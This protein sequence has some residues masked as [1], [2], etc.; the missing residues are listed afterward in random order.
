[1]DSHLDLDTSLGEALHDLRQGVLALG[2]GHSVSRHDDD[3]FRCLQPCGH[4]VHLHGRAL[5]CDVG[6]EIANRKLLPLEAQDVQKCPV[7]RRAHDGRQN[8]PAGADQSADD[9]QQRI[10]Q[11]EAL[12]SKCPAGGAVKQ[13][14]DDR[15]VGTADLARHDPTKNRGDASSTE[16]HRVP[17]STD[18]ADQA[19]IESNEEECQEGLLAWEVHGPA[20]HQALQLGEGQQAACDRKGA[21]GGGEVCRHGEQRPRAMRGEG[22]GDGCARSG[23]THKAVEGRNKLGQICD[24]DARS[25]TNTQATAKDHCAQHLHQSGLRHTHGANRASKSTS[26]THDAKRIPNGRGLLR[27]QCADGLDAQQRRDEV[28]HRRQAHAARDTKREE[29][30]SWQREEGAVGGRVARA[31]EHLQHAASHDEAS[32]NIHH[33]NED[34]DGSKHLRHRLRIV[35]TPGQHQASHN[36]EAADRIGHRHQRRVQSSCNAGDHLRPDQTCKAEGCGQRSDGASHAA[37]AEETRDASGVHQR[38]A[39]RGAEGHLLGVHDLCLLH[40][41]LLLWRGRRWR[42]VLRLRQ[43]LA[44]LDDPAATDGLIFLVQVEARLVAHGDQ[45]LGDIVREQLRGLG[46]RGLN[47]VCP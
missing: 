6:R 36:G 41:G 7:H 45:E 10:R 27:R 4:V 24:L 46:G 44:I 35:A 47:H 38:L 13:R 39:E 21:D 31:A 5:A 20:G 9:R 15:H 34:G 17:R 33:G 14:D 42:L 12:C 32:S 26:N 18:V 43:P 16:K 30:A 1:M 19:C 37:E 28:Y 22:G 11:H 25:D 8:R 40:H 3:L 29:D 23:H 2:D